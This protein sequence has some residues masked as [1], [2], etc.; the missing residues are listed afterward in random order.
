M[1][2]LNHNRARLR[3]RLESGRQVRR[4]ADHGLLLS[5]P[6]AEQIAN[7]HRPSRD[8]HPHTQRT[9][10]GDELRGCIHES[11]TRPHRM[12]SVILMRPGIAEIGEDAVAHVFADEAAMTGDKRRA[13]MV[14]G[15]EDAAHILRIEPGGHCGR[16]RQVAKHDGQLT[17]LGGVLVRGGLRRPR[18]HRCFARRRR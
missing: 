10:R 14:I 12:L 13:T 5:G 6:G 3:D 7:D 9:G 8:P 16:A 17:A 18:G 11:Q 1:L 15:G 4:V 2:E